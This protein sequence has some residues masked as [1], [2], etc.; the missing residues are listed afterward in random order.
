MQ[1]NL[2]ICHAPVVVVA[3]NALVCV[4]LELDVVNVLAP[5]CF[6]PELLDDLVDVSH[7]ACQAAQHAQDTTTLRQAIACTQLLKAKETTVIRNCDSCAYCAHQ[8]ETGSIYYGR[9]KLTESTAGETLP[10]ELGKQEMQT[11]CAA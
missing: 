4:G 9:Q 5:V 7:L 1:G 3:C 8:N 11:E 6:L 2:D 10:Q